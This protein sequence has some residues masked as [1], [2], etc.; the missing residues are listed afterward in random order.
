A[1]GNGC[2]ACARSSARLFFRGHPRTPWEGPGHHPYPTRASPPDRSRRRSAD[3]EH[4][5]SDRSAVGEVLQRPA[6][7]LERVRGPDERL[8]A[9]PGDQGL[10]A[11][12][13][14][15]HEAGLAGEE[16]PPRRPEDADVA[17]QQPVDLHAGDVTA[18]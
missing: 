4:E 11:P 9:A 10:E 7:V 3:R 18:G 15:G 16:L 1:V 6:A 17:E 12:G 5:L 2:W 14:L 13:G 8:Q